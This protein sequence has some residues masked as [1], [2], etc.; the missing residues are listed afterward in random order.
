VAGGETCAGDVGG[1]SILRLDARGGLLGRPL[2]SINTT[3]K[4]QVRGFDCPEEFIEGQLNRWTCDVEA[5]DIVGCWTFSIADRAS[6]G[7]GG[8]VEGVNADIV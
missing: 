3:A 5:A 2:P 8:P 7:G 4:P 1:L 6:T